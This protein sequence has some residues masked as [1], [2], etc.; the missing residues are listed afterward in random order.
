[1]K[2]ILS[3]LFVSIFANARTWPT[4]LYENDKNATAELELIEVHHDLDDYKADPDMS[5]AANA[6]DPLRNDD[7]RDYDVIVVGNKMQKGEIPAQSVRVYVRGEGLKYFWNI[8][9]ARRGKVTPSGF[10]VPQYFS[11]QHESSIYS[12][13][14]MPWAVFFNGNIASH[15]TDSISRLG[16]PASAGC[17]R[18]EPSRAH[19]LFH[20]IGH[21]E[22]TWIDQIGQDGRPTGEKILSYRTLIIVE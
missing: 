6:D 1:M 5:L 10:F 3:I 14:K 17:I 22:R 11:S 13:A 18:L 9:S 15:G 19:N 20:L 8:S 4:A 2:I 12:L 7:Y 21:T 16:E